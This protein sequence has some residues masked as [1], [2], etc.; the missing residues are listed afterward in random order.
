MNVAPGGSFFQTVQGSAASNGPA[1]TV[2][3]ARPSEPVDTIRPAEN[4]SS[5]LARP[6]SDSPRGRILDIVV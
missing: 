5:Q 2:Q 4:P 3:T 1:Q 6:P